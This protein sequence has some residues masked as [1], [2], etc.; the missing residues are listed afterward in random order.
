M[1]LLAC[2]PPVAYAGGFS[3]PEQNASGM[4]NA[5][6]GATAIAEDASTIYY[7]PAG[8]VHISGR[9][10]VL[11]GTFIAIRNSLDNQGSTPAVRSPTPLTFQ[12]TGEN[13]RAR[14]YP[15]L[16]NAYFSQAISQKW[17][18]GLGIGSEFGLMSDYGANWF[19]RYIVTKAE[20]QTV[21]LNPTVA[22]AL[23]DTVSVGAGISYITANAK[24]NNVTN[25][26][27][28]GDAPTTVDV[29]DNAWGAN[30][31]VLWSPDSQTRIGLAYRSSYRLKLT[32]SIATTFPGTPQQ[33]ALLPAAQQGALAAA[34]SAVQVDLKLPDTASLG[35][36][37]ALN[38]RVE[39]LADLTWTNWSVFKNLQVINSAA[40]LPL[41]TVPQQ[42]KDAYRL[43]LGVNI[44]LAPE[45]KLR[46]GAGY[47]Q[48]PVS[49]AY[50]SPIIPDADRFVLAV[51]LQYKPNKDI[52]IDAGYIHAFV[53][54]ISINDAPRDALG[55]RLAGA[56]TVLAEGKQNIDVL[57][58]QVRYNF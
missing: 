33:Q 38:D 42:W 34:N 21:T 8:L 13:G 51:G 52:A 6:A 29:R 32:G 54:K 20:M 58:V 5:Y 1:A 46:L 56:G 55:N 57:G 9:Q 16:G 25:F 49:N 14:E 3:I 11:G 24:L 28:F 37:H 15:L 44:G 4:G 31:G 47:D 19:G 27:I 35:I 17:H 53:H 7:N 50:R 43:A 41:V 45:W 40:G 36:V 30:V 12:P 2:I 48:S 10:V 26:G 23:S 22:Y 39:L 18:W